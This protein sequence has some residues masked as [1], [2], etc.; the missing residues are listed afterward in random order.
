MH[1][2]LRRLP[3]LGNA[4]AMPGVVFEQPAEIAGKPGPT[5]PRRIADCK[6]NPKRSLQ[7]AMGEEVR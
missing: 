1:H 4:K 6:E 7:N 3:I 2:P 5:A